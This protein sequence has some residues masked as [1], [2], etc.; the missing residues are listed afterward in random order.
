MFCHRIQEGH[1]KWVVKILVRGKGRFWVVFDQ[2]P[3]WWL[4]QVADELF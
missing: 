1:G 4:L 3:Y 2:K